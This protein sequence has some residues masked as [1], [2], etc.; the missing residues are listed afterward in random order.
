VESLAEGIARLE[1]DPCIGVRLRG[2]PGDRVVC[3]LRIGGRRPS[4]R[5]LYSV[6]PP[7]P[8]P[9]VYLVGE[10]YLPIEPATYLGKPK[11]PKDR[12]AV[13][14]GMPDVYADFARSL[15]LSE[16]EIRSMIEEIKRGVKQP[17][18]C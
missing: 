18:C 16:T 3:E 4:W 17:A 15:G 8:R 5:I 7:G 12:L 13:R 2:V 10:H 6:R 1:Q 11:I 9:N 14:A